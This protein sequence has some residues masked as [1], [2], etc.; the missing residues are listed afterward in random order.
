LGKFLLDFTSAVILISGPMARFLFTAR[1]MFWNGAS[2]SMR[3]GVWLQLS[4]THTPLFHV[5]SGKM[6]LAF[7][8]TGNL[9]F[10]S[11]QELCPNLYSFQTFTCLEMRPPLR[12][13]KWFDYYSLSDGCWFWVSH[14][15]KLLLA[16]A[17]MIIL[18][19]G[20]CRTHGHIFLPHGSDCVAA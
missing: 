6:L 8:R 11:C 12:R 18:G 1:H 4:T 5:W 13:Q 16:F 9:G 2:S 10:V 17:S 7:T 19:S 3:G 14:S 15:S 20:P